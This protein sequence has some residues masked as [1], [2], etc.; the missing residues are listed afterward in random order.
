MFNLLPQ[1]CKERFLIP[2]L[3]QVRTCAQTAVHQIT[4]K[5][6]QTCKNIHLKES[7]TKIHVC[8]RTMLGTQHTKP[9]QEKKKYVIQHIFH[10]VAKKLLLHF[11]IAICRKIL[12]VHLLLWSSHCNSY[13]I[14]R[15]KKE[16]TGKYSLCCHHL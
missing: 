13:V 11:P 1:P 5:S 4:S 3:L 2:F 10:F 7:H 15:G 14:K 16:N 12:V 6:T 9:Q 8:F